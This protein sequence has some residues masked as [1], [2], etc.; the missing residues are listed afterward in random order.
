M[1]GLTRV[2]HYDCTVDMESDP[3]RVDLRSSE[4]SR[5]SCPA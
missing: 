1:V 3:A 4:L 2:G 5:A